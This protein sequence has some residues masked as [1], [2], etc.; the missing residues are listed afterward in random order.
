MLINQKHVHRTHDG[1][2]GLLPGN[3]KQQNPLIYPIPRTVSISKGAEMPDKQEL[4]QQQG[5]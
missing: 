2:H 3:K 1:E 4:E 5:P